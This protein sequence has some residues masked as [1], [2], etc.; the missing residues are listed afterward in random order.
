MNE[1]DLNTFLSEYRII[2]KYGDAYDLISDRMYSTANITLQQKKQK[3][4][5]FFTRGV[6]P[7]FAPMDDINSYISGWTAADLDV[8]HETFYAGVTYFYSLCM[9]M[10][11]DMAEVSTSEY[12]TIGY[13]PGAANMYGAFKTLF[14]QYRLLSEYPVFYSLT[15]GNTP[16][17]VSAFTGVTARGS[18]A[19]CY[20]MVN[21]GGVV[22]PF[23]LM[24]NPNTIN[25]SN[26]N[27]LPTG[28]GGNPLYFGLPEFQGIT[29]A[30]KSI[31][32]SPN[33]HQSLIRNLNLYSIYGITFTGILADFQPHYQFI[34]FADDTFMDTQ[35]DLISKYIAADN[36]GWLSEY[37]ALSGSTAVSTNQVGYQLANNFL[38]KFYSDIV[39]Y[40]RKYRTNQSAYNIG[41]IGVPYSTE[42]LGWQKSIP[43][44]DTAVDGTGP[45]ASVGDQYFVTRLAGLT[46]FPAPAGYTYSGGLTGWNSYKKAK[47]NTT[48]YYNEYFMLG[49]SAQAASAT[50]SASN[51]VPA[52][53]LTFFTDTFE[54]IGP[55]GLTMNYLESYYYNIYQETIKY[56]GYRYANVYPINFIPRFNPLFPMQ[57]K[58][59][60]NPSKNFRSRR[61]CTI[62]QDFGGSTAERLY[63]LKESMK[64]S[65]QT[66]IRTWKL[67]LDNCGKYNYRIL[68]VIRGRNEDL[69]LTRGGSVPYSPQDFVDY[70]VA[71]LFSG[72]VPAN[73]FIIDDNINDLLLQTFYYG[74]IARGSTEYTNVVTNGGV[75]GAD[76]ATAFIRGL[77][78]YFFDLE[79][80]QFQMSFGSYLD[81]MGIT[82]SAANFTEY[83]NKF[84]SG[85]FSDYR[86][87]ETYTGFSGGNSFIPYGKAYFKWNFVPIR[88]GS[89]LDTN[90]ELKQRW[91]SP[92]NDDITTAYEIIRDAYFELT[93][94]QIQAAYD[95]FTA[96][97][98]TTYVQYRSTDKA[99]GR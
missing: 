50:Y 39:I 63:N 10:F 69:D 96:N 59:T 83:M 32:F 78:T 33:I 54:K 45:Y 5:G 26:N 31:Y 91:K 4:L 38:N 2:T 21:V 24:F 28:T 79:D 87:F 66:S 40:P 47:G 84:N 3:P 30:I 29:N 67:L 17:P 77:E 14:D 23:Q 46:F 8:E 65:I 98:I 64:Q 71:P 7:Y 19:G 9:E 97:N 44:P 58:G 52:N 61:D 6:M 73:G 35:T 62:H 27:G 74:N 93:K 72:E 41:H 90:Q 11:Y 85:R 42:I 25:I 22:T 95:Y 43:T 76:S 92:T 37:R 89:I 15:G 81:Q 75:S 48:A 86:V 60:Y 49:G 36:P 55:D 80:L 12:G 1:K 56:G 88:S 13:V 53:L 82:A 57:N 16:Y 70:I 34:K 99:I 68:P 20:T 18:S 51:V 94:K